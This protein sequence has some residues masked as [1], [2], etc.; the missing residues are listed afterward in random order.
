MNQVIKRSL[1]PA[2]V[3]IFVVEFVIHSQDLNV[4]INVTLNN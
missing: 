1:V 3:D 2:N 4:V